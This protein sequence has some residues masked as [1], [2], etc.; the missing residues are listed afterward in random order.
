MCGVMLCCCVVAN[1]I[2]LWVGWC[3]VFRWLRLSCYSV[4]LDCCVVLSAAVLAAALLHL[5]GFAALLQMQET[6][7]CFVLMLDDA[8]VLCMI[9]LYLMLLLCCV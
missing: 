8:V 9:L 5:K 2:A 3:C 1:G 6:L 7:Q 4:V